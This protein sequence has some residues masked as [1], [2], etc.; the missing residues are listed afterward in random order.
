MSTIFQNPIP[1]FPGWGRRIYRLSRPVTDDDIQAFLGNEELYTRDTSSGLVNI[2][3][4][5]GLLEI[6]CISGESEMEV[7]YDREK[8]SYSSEYIDAL[9]ST[10][11]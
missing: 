9:L 5:F 4:K 8:K 3:H 6:N 7:W 10:R 11:F 1:P 2:I